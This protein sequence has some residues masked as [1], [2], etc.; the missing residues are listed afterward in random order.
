MAYIEKE[1]AKYL[2]KQDVLDY[3][4]DEITVYAI[5]NTADDP[6]TYVERYPR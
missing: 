6:C 5:G 2:R 4:L 1:I 3:A